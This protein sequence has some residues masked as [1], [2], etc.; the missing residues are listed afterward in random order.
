MLVYT[1]G[2]LFFV[3]AERCVAS[4]H[5]WMFFQIFLTLLACAVLVVEFYVGEQPW[6]LVVE[7]AYARLV[8]CAEVL[9]IFVAKSNRRRYLS[10]A[11]RSSTPR[12]SSSITLFSFVLHP[13]S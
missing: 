3:F 8:L 12:F 7:V 10:R 6:I 2:L 1:I 13:I 5:W 9:Q 4:G 11:L